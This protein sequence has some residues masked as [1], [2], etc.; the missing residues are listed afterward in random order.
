MPGVPQWEYPGTGGMSVEE[1]KNISLPLAKNAIVFLWTTVGYLPQALEVFNAWGL[2]YKNLITWK[3]TTGGLGHWGRVVTEHCLMGV[4]G[5]PIADFDKIS[6]HVEGQKSEHGGK[7]DEF[8]IMISRAC[9]GRKLDILG[10]EKREGWDL[11]ASL[12]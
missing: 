11:K 10:V 1:I 12:E 4:I 6:N 5:K 7:P 2:E 9:P 8:Y 3:K